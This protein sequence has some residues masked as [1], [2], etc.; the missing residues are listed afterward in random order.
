MFLEF[1][2]IV[3]ED[4]SVRIWAW[5]GILQSG[6]S[7]RIHVDNV[8]ALHAAENGLSLRAVTELRAN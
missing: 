6:Q 2:N 7:L 5:A 1:V 3:G 4:G 8:H